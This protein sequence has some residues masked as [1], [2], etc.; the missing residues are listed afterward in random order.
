[1]THYSHPHDILKIV[2]AHNGDIALVIV[3]DIS[4][5]TL[6]ARGALMA[7]T[8]DADFGYISAG[9][10]DGDIIFQAR[11][12]LVDGA[13]RELVYGEGSP[14]KD[15]TLPCGGTIKLRIIPGPDRDV[16]KAAVAD[17]DARQSTVLKISDLVQ[18]YKPKLRLRIVG[19]GAP[20]AALARLAG[21]SGFEIY[22]QSPDA[23]MW[24]DYFTGFDHLTDPASPPP[25]I[26]DV[27]TAAVF[28][29]HD[30]DWEPALLSQAL[31]GDAFY[32]GA[33]GSDQTH[34]AR[35]ESLRAMGAKNI[36]R[37]KGP[38]GLLPAMRDA[39][40]LAV[41]ILAEIIDAAQTQELLP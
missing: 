21:A 40:L 38:I 36:G 7:V 2:A 16:I 30:H 22:G 19:R 25:L 20:F 35:L 12:A 31:S 14:F 1:M 5:G 32:I 11:A 28:L 26:D 23:D 6:R 18:T 4:G 27:W 39:G 8:P 37:I 41:S 13:A 33:M 10:V 29:F 3:T 17:L 34:R 24:Q 9:C 15:I